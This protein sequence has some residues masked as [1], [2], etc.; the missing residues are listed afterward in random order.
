MNF[1]EK[2]PW[3]LRQMMTQISLPLSLANFHDERVKSALPSLSIFFSP[4]A[5]HDS[6]LFAYHSSPHAEKE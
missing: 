4:Q 2:I 5:P 6:S 3:H 1:V